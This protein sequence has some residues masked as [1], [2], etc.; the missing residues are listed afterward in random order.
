MHLTIDDFPTR[1]G[2]NARE[3]HITRS[4]RVKS[5]RAVVGW[6]L[7][8]KPKPATPCI[9]T[10]TRFAP[11]AG[12]DDDNLASALK[13]VRDSFAEWISVDDKHR[14]IVR[15]RYEQA[16]GPWAVRIEVEA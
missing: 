5:E 13:G 12:L 3:H 11:S 2:M 7:R 10:L 6:Y 16:R 9:V 1:G 4:R 15:Y 8:A 14:D